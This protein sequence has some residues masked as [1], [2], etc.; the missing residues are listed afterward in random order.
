MNGKPVEAKFS[1]DA[2]LIPQC[3]FATWDKPIDQKCSKCG[4]PMLV[5]K[6][7]KRKGSYLRCLSC[8]DEQMLPGQSQIV[9]TDT[10]GD[11]EG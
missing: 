8:K 4:Y 10:S 11:L 7:T 5:Q 2:M 1:M 6:D 9:E 3:N